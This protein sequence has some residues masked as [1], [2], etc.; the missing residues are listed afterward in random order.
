MTHYLKINF[1]FLKFEK[2]KTFLKK[3]IGP[4]G[5]GF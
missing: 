2:T 3:V 5:I 1:F 4:F